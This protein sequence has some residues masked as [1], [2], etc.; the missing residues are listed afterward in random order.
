M[1]NHENLY[2]M[3][4]NTVKLFFYQH[5]SRD[6]AQMLNFCVE[7]I[8]I[9]FQNVE[10]ML[11]FCRYFFLYVEK[12][13]EFCRDFAKKPLKSL[14]FDHVEFFMLNCCKDFFMKC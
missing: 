12:N 3:N 4:E 2:K 7:S 11:N 5:S 10:F 9:F 8:K 13:V 1:E 14:R 6:F